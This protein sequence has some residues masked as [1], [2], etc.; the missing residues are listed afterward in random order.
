MHLFKYIGIPSYY[1]P[2]IAD[3]IAITCALVLV[4]IILNHKFKFSYKELL[5]Y[6]LK[7]IIGIEVMLIALSI[8]RYAYYSTINVM[9]SIITIVLYTVIGAFIYFV[10]VKEF[11]LIEDIFGNDFKD[12]L[13]KKLKLK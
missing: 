8:L 13:L 3:A 12:K 7:V 10:V 6:L 1:A 9:S 2:T 4:L 5:P 11:R